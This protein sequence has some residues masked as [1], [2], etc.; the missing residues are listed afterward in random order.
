MH[1]AVLS[2]VA[3]HASA[4][5]RDGCTV[6][7]FGSRD[8]NGT[9]RSVFTASRYVGV[10]SI[11]GP[12]VDIVADAATVNVGEQ[13]DV[14]VCTEV[15]EHVDDITAAAICANA[16]RHLAPGGVLVAT[17]AGIGRH[18]HSA[19]D[20]RGLHPGEFYRNVDAPTL[21]D[22]LS[23]AGFTSFEIDIAGLDIRCTARKE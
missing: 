3:R 11:D 12:C 19:I 23:S 2:Y 1:D 13:F 22:W 21:A 18:E 15:L 7:E 14:V 10:D 17:M 9:A 4:G 20:G 5:I 6:L 8:I 16:W